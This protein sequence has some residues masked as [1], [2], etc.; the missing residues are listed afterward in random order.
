MRGKLS[1]RRTALLEQ[2]AVI[3]EA[4]RQLEEEE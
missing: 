3:D 4:M 2:L 1:A